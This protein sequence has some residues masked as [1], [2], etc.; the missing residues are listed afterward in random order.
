MKLKD[1]CSLEGKLWQ[2]YDKPKQYIQRQGYHFSDTGPYSQSCGYSNSHVQMWDWTIEKAECWRIDTLN[3]GEEE[4]S[5]N[6]CQ[7]R[8]TSFIRNIYDKDFEAALVKWWKQIIKNILHGSEISKRENQKT[9]SLCFFSGNIKRQS[10][11]C[12]YNNPIGA[13]GKPLENIQRST[14]AKLMSNQEKPTLR[15]TGNCVAFTLLCPTKP[16]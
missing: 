8:S 15:M 10:E 5:V 13:S 2:T 7:H 16:A 11:N 9:P 12:W 6:T 1:A 3:Y 4:K 14:A